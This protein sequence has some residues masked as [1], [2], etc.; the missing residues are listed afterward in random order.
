M[1]KVFTQ[2]LCTLTAGLAIAGAAHAER[3]TLKYTATISSIEDH[4][5]SPSPSYTSAS[6]D[7]NVISIDDT[8]TGYFTFDTAMPPTH[9]STSSAQYGLDE[10][11]GHVIVFDKTGFSQQATTYHSEINVTTASAGGWD[12][13]S[14]SFHAPMYY[15]DGPGYVAMTTLSFQAPAGT[16]GDTALPATLSP[17]TG[18]FAYAYVSFEDNETLYFQGDI[19]SASI[20]SSVPEPGTYAMLLVGLGLVAWRRRAR[21]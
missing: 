3:Y 8:V 18:W 13:D 6:A 12:H 11:F 16:L 2:A 20:V 7:G 1:L 15:M 4:Q 10:A 9:S 14:V 17:F 19:T 5:Q 21:D